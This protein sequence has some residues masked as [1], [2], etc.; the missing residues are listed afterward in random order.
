M[1][2]GSGEKKTLRM[3]AQY[4][5]AC[6][7]FPSPDMAHKLDVLREHCAAVG[8][9]YDEIEKTTMHWEPSELDD[10]G[11]DRMIEKFAEYAK[12]GFQSVHLSIIPPHRA[13]LVELVGERVI[14][15]VAGF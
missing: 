1:V 8:R 11:I 9:D 10:A 4:A 15:A 12:L 13:D 5:D 7:I 14:P 6:N 3:V 2:G